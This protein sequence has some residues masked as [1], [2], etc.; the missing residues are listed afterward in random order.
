ML[1]FVPPL[2]VGVNVFAP[3]VTIITGVEVVNSSRRNR[4][5][6]FTTRCC[7]KKDK[8]DIIE[9][10]W[11]AIFGAKEQEPLGLKRFDRDRFPELYYGTLDEFADPVQSDDELA[12]AF[13]PMLART[14]LQTRAVQ[15]L[16]D[17]N[18]DGWSAEE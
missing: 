5:V 9:R 18:R 12:A 6:R 1:G 14:Q 17:A 8:G 16:Y 15:L 13:R 4:L 10:V 3:K 11:T 2:L 7:E